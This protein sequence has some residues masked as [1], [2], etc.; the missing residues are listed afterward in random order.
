M[1][2]DGCGGEVR[3]GGG[4]SRTLCCPCLCPGPELWDASCSPPA[5]HNCSSPHLPSEPA[6]SSVAEEL[7]SCPEHLAG[8]KTTAHLHRAAWL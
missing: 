3:G 1:P 7:L 2:R 4:L 5:T 8:C 6:H